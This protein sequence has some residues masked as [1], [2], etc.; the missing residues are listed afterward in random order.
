[1]L[2]SVDRDFL[3]NATVEKTHAAAEIAEDT[4]GHEL[5]KFVE[6][7]PTHSFEPTTAPRPAAC[8]DEIHALA[9]RDHFAYVLRLDLKVRG[10]REYLPAAAMAEPRHQRRSFPECAI[11]LND[12]RH[13]P[14]AGQRR[15]L[16]RH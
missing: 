9:R 14:I 4:A 13:D 5:Q 2:V 15:A 11:Q 16:R 7:L 12:L 3:E 1:M 8:D 10:Q 6:P